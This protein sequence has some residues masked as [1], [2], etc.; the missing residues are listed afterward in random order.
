MKLSQIERR[1]CFLSIDL[2]Y[3]PHH[4]R[5]MSSETVSQTLGAVLLRGEDPL[6]RHDGWRRAT[7]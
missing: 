6:S 7:P 2:E 1:Y 3:Y 4:R 5:L